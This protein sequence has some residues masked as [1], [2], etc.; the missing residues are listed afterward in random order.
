MR[1]KKNSKHPPTVARQ[2]IIVIDKGNFMFRKNAYSDDYYNT[3]HVFC[4]NLNFIYCTSRV[5]KLHV[6]IL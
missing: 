6:G 2:I 5:N 4:E 3:V 1:M